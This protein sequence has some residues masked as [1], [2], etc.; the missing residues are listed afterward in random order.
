MNSDC[1][2][3]LVRVTESCLL[4]LHLASHLSSP[5]VLSRHSSDNMITVLNFL[6]EI[7]SSFPRLDITV[8]ASLVSNIA[9]NLK[10]VLSWEWSWSITP[11]ILALRRLMEEDA[12]GLRQSGCRGTPVSSSPEGEFLRKSTISC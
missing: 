8:K 1:T 10:I 3:S 11:I 6:D 7:R 5:Y 9:A 2:P 4:F 12:I